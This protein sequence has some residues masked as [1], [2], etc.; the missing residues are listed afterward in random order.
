M[1]ISYKLIM[2][3]ISQMFCLF[4]AVKAQKTCSETNSLSDYDQWEVK[5]QKYLY[6]CGNR[7]IPSNVKN[8]S[9]PLDV[10]VS[11][12]L[13]HFT[14]TSSSEQD[15]YIYTWVVISWEDGRIKWDPAKFDG[16]EF[17][18]NGFIS[19]EFWAPRHIERLDS[20]DNLEFIFKYAPCTMHNSGYVE[21][22]FKMYMNN[23]CVA[24]LREWPRDAQICSVTLAIKGDEKD[25]VRLNFGNKAVRM[26]GSE[27]G[28][29]WDIMGYD[30]KLNGK[31][32]VLSFTLERHAEVLVALVIYPT[33]ILSVLSVLT[34][35]LDVRSGFRLFLASFILMCHLYYL[36]DLASES[37]V[38]R[39]NNTPMI[40]LYFRGSVI[41]VTLNIVLTVTLQLLCGRVTSVPAWIAITNEKVYKTPLKF[42]IFPRRKSAVANDEHVKNIKDWTDFANIVNCVWCYAT[43]VTYISFYFVLVP[44]ERPWN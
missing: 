29:E 42:V 25:K 5:L 11:L 3:L 21:C 16:I 20:L 18:T 39:G 36:P 37:S 43:V 22:V 10:S 8:Q 2:K 26:I 34:V 40:I 35:V 1:C 28:T 12:R 31:Q 9:E 23:K 13:K 27:Y 38:Q 4:L 17:I 7:L 32:L 44:P 41:M 24:D 15:F 6:K 19:H 33:V 30:Q 14:Y